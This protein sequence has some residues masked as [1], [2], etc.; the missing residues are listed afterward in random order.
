LARSRTATWRRRAA[1]HASAVCSSASGASIFH[2]LLPPRD[3]LRFRDLGCGA[4]A[5][6]RQVLEGSPALRRPSIASVRCS[7]N[8]QGFHVR[9]VDVRQSPKDRFDGYY[10]PRALRARV[11]LTSSRCSFLVPL[12]EEADCASSA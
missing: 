3:G 7:P 6:D 12:H 10:E 5:F 4:R 8:R 2:G 1:G 11:P 9:E